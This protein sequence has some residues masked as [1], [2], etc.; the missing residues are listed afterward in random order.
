MM[1]WHVRKWYR[2]QHFMAVQQGRQFAQC[3][4]A[5]TYNEEFGKGGGDLL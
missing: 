1:N 4:W 2:W 3:V 5:T